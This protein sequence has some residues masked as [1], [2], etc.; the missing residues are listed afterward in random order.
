[1]SEYQNGSKEYLKQFKWQRL[2]E[3]CA[4]LDPE[5]EKALAEE[6]MAVVLEAWPEY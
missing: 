3:E 5:A 6:G 1:M 4:K 2:A